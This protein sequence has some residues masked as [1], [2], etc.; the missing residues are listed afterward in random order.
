MKKLFAFA[1][2]AAAPASAS[3]LVTSPTTVSSPGS[4]PLHDGGQARCK[5]PNGCST[6]M[7]YAKVVAPYGTVMEQVVLNGWSANVDS[8]GPVRV[9]VVYRIG[10]SARPYSGI[11]VRADEWEGVAS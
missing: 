8:N 5:N 3:V 10:D 11:Y 2:V 6:I 9:L 1:L 4:A 7:P